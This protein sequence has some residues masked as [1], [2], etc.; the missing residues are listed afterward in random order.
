MSHELDSSEAKELLKNTF[1]RPDKEDV[2]FEL[3]WIIKII[4][5]FE[6]R[7]YSLIEPGGNLVARW[8]QD[9]YEYKIYHDSIG[10]FEF[11]EKMDAIDEI[12]K[13]KDNFLG[14][15]LKVLEKI[16]QLSGLR[17]DSLWGGRPDILLEKFDKNDNL[18]SIF[19]GEVKYTQ[20]KDY[21]I[22]GL[23]E[24]LEYMALIKQK[25]EYVETYKH[26]FRGLGKV[27]GCL[28]LDRIDNFKI[29]IIKDF[30]LQ[31]VMFGDDVENMLYED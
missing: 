31:I 4:K 14:R 26:L 17:I 15:E 9:E 25:G 2:L 24:I 30:P 18:I 13:D 12:L 19:I 1:I 6:D 21:A 10:S 3:Y 23:R 27:K 7:I 8:K 11:K 16:E 29:H 5:Q 20:N 22:K 28:F